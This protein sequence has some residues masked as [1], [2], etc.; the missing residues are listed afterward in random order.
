MVHGGVIMPGS[1]HVG[2][3]VGAQREQLHRPGGAVGQVLRRRAGE[4]RQDALQGSGVIVLHILNLCNLG[5]RV[6]RQLVHNGDA[7]IHDFHLI[8]SFSI[9]IYLKRL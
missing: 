9:H 8:C 3:G 7:Q 6:N 5:T 1:V 4:H 2:A